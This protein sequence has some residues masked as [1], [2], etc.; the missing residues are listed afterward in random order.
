MKTWIIEMPDDWNKKDYLTPEFTAREA[1]EVAKLECKGESNISGL[2]N[3]KGVKF[4]AV[5]M[6]DNK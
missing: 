5:I 2:K 6:E 4:Y 1:V 3:V